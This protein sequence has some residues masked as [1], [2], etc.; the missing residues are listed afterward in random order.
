VGSRLLYVLLELPYFLAHPLEIFY[1][2]K[3]GLIFHGGLV[4]A[5][6]VAGFLIHRHRLPWRGTL[7]ALAVGMPAGQAIGRIGCFMAGCCYG[8]PAPNLPWAV[9]F[10]APETLC[11]VKG[12]VHPTQ[13]YEALLLA[14]VF[15]IIYKLR[16]RKRFDGQLTLTY[17]FLAGWVRF[18]VEFFRSPLDYR[19]PEL[20]WHMPLTQVIALGLAL[21]SGALLWWVWWVKKRPASTGSN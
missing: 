2:W 13:L 14:G 8:R 11:P 21:L 1:L 10:T 5:L 4:L 9:T 7:D 3:G 17:F 15:A 19:G 6:A 18:G 12:P 20:F 16:T